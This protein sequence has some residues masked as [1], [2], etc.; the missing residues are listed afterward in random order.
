LVPGAICRDRP[1]AERSS[2]LGAFDG[3]C[4]RSSS[5]RN[6]CG[7][8]LNFGEGSRVGIGVNMES[9]RERVLE[10]VLVIVW[11]IAVGIPLSSVVCK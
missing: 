11:A 4:I 6:L 1:L 7:G 2:R 5:S 3:V 8:S 9:D 10:G